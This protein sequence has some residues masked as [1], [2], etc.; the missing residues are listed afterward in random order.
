MVPHDPDT[1]R[2]LWNALADY[3][4]D[5]ARSKRRRP[6]TKSSPPVTPA[7]CSTRQ[8]QGGESPEKAPDSDGEVKIALEGPSPPSKGVMSTLRSKVPR[9]SGRSPAAKAMPDSDSEVEIVAEGP[10][11][12]R[13]SPSKVVRS[14]Q[15]GSLV[16]VPNSDSEVEIVAEG[17]SP[18]KAVTPTANR[19]PIGRPTSRSGSGAESSS[20]S[21]P[22]MGKKRQR[23][24]SLLTS[25]EKSKR[26]WCA[27]DVVVID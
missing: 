5:R 25:T 12:L 23:V 19:Q 20:R 11:P 27:K 10:S 7:K 17:P 15:G 22:P 1:R 24:P 3:D 2:R 18:S 13:S 6:P 4:K 26:R 9:G 16:T 14:G 21:M 8:V